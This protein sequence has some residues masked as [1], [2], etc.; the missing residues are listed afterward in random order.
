MRHGEATDAARLGLGGDDLGDAGLG[1]AEAGGADELGEIQDLVEGRLLLGAGDLEEREKP[2]LAA[3]VREGG[4][5]V[6]GL[7]ARE[8]PQVGVDGRGGEEK[9]FRPGRVEEG[10]NRLMA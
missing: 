3:L 10:L 6:A 7:E 8:P 9:D 1:I 4:E 2:D 5:G